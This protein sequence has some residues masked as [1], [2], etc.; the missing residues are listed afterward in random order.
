MSLRYVCHHLSLIPSPAVVAFLNNSSIIK[1]D[2]H[3]QVLEVSLEP[4]QRRL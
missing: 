1:R 2:S 3:E 4:G